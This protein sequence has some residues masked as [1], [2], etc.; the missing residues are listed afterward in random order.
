[1]G[2]HHPVGLLACHKL[3]HSANE[4]PVKAGLHPVIEKLSVAG[5][6]EV[7]PY[8]RVSLDQDFVTS[9]IPASKP[10]TR[11]VKHID[12]SGLDPLRAELFFDSP[13]SARVTIACRRT[14][15]QNSHLLRSSI[16]DSVGH[17]LA[18]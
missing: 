1:V 16:R 17:I 8:L 9:S 5:P 11:V 3:S 10:F 13:G 7:A 12:C 2:A 14:Q 4:Q 15:K 18:L 6:V